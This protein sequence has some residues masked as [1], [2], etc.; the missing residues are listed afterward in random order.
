M[1]RSN[2]GSEFLPR[3]IPRHRVV[4]QS[5]GM[6]NFICGVTLTQQLTTRTRVRIRAWNRPDTLSHEYK[7]LTSPSACA[8][9]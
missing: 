2:I 5:G 9:C 6:F 1:F 3:F 4:E 8:I 7:S